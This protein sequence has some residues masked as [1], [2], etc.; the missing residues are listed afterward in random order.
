MPTKPTI[1]WMPEKDAA[2]MLGLKPQTL[3]KYVKTGKWSIALSRLSERCYL[4]SKGDI[5]NLLLE[6]STV[7]S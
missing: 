1:H 7:L 6:N 3:R 4:Y 5:D 2:A